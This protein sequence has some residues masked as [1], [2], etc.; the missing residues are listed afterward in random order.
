MSH[1]TIFQTSDL[2]TH[3]APT[4]PLNT[5][6]ETTDGHYLVSPATQQYRHQRQ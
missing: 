2:L 6:S 3:N 1:K 5:V 4:Y